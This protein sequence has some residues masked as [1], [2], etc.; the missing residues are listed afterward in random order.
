MRIFLSWSG[1][2]SK[3][4]AAT[5]RKHLPMI[6]QSLDVFMSKHDIESGARWAHELADELDKA[7]FGI[8]CLT[9]QNLDS[10]WLLF[11]AGSLVKHAD[12]RACGLLIGNFSPTEITGPL[13]QFQHRK[14]EQS[15]FLHLL[16]DINNKVDRS[17]SSDELSELLKKFWPDIEAEYKAALK[18]QQNEGNKGARPTREIMEEILTRLRSVE[19]EQQRPDEFRE[20]AQGDVL[21]R[22]ISVDA[23][24]WYSLWKFPSK[25]VSENIQNILLRDL[26]NSKYRKIE[27]IDRAVNRA[28]KAVEAYA[29]DNPDFFKFGTDHI[30]KSLGFVDRNFRSRHGF[31]AATLKAFDKYE[32]LVESSD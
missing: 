7:S 21:S 3:I 10:P 26:D 6:I 31:A 23:I 4:V 18:S 11:E 5:L 1:P 9:P 24:A 27:D 19:T 28:H 12:G 2:A 14:F 25:P 16:K 29:K 22:P 15:E 17:L 13:A 32:K 8:L 20:T 30:T